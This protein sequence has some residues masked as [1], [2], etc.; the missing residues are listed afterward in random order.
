MKC[1]SMWAHWER[2]SDRLVTH[3]LRP[4]MAEVRRP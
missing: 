4:L 3:Y 1:L 2:K